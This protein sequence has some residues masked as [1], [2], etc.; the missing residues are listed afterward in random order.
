MCWIVSDFCAVRNHVG[1]NDETLDQNLDVPS[2]PIIS[3]RRSFGLFRLRM[4]SVKQKQKVFAPGLF[5]DQFGHVRIWISSDQSWSGII[6][7][8]MA[9]Y[10]RLWQTPRPRSIWTVHH[11][12]HAGTPGTCSSQTTSPLG[13]STEEILGLILR[14]IWPKTMT[15][16]EER[17][18]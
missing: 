1:R 15:M 3:S 9:R 6:K 14:S 10:D 12:Y 17:L 18:W 4:C 13:L 16:I 5:W 7:I 8:L 11:H 2:H